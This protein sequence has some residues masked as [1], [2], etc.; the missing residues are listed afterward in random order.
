MD[1]TNA[2]AALLAGRTMYLDEIVTASGRSISTVRKVLKSAGF[3]QDYATMA[4]GYEAPV[5]VD[6]RVSSDRLSPWA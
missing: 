4:W 1:T 2:I 3:F 6:G 5:A